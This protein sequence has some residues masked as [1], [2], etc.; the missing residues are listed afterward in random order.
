MHTRSLLIILALAVLIL[1]GVFAS[2]RRPSTDGPPAAGTPVAA[3]A[4]GIPEVSLADGE[5]LDLTADEADLPFAGKTRRVLAYN[6]SVP[7]PLIRVAQGSE[8]AIRFRNRLDH[9]TT[10]HAH[11]VRM[12][13]AFDGVPDV[14]QRPVKPGE[15]FTYR[16]RFPDP[17]A[18]WYH[19]HIR[20]DRD[21]DLGLLGMFLVTP[22][23]AAYWNPVDRELPLVLDDILLDRGEPVPYP[24]DRADHALMGRFGETM[25]VNGQ[26][27]YRLDAKT[28]ERI[29]LFVLNA[30]NTRPFRLA[31]R[32]ADLRL[33]GGDGGRMEREERTDAVLLGPSERAV[34]E[35]RFNRAGSYALEHRTPDRTYAL[36]TVEVTGEDAV[37]GSEPADR[38]ILDLPAH[39]AQWRTAEPDKA[40]RFDV[41][42]RM[43][44]AGQQSGM[45]GHGM[46]MGETMGSGMAGDLPE[47]G[48]EWED[49]G[50]PMN[51]M[52][53]S[54]LV[55][56]KLVDAQSGKENEDIDWRFPKGGFVKVLLLNDPDSAH[57]M[58]HPIHFHGQ[59]FLVLSRDGVPQTNLVWKDTVFVRAGETV[60]VLIEVSNPGTWAMHCHIP[61]HMESGMMGTFEII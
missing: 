23:D 20:E 16:L 51:A 44:P 13:N 55:T 33:V 42:L 61:E 56:W 36:G 48:I 35:V 34:V 7:G 59:R 28:G 18:Y 21:Q 58:Q 32:G 8:V 19:P 12:D 49:P 43:M 3:P 29:R 5:T 54:K 26:T 24:A 31:I 27:R 45:G 52:S 40:L 38:G 50:D 14:T 15:T 41:D 9:D 57:P 22:A 53:T 60:D 25:L 4:A 46:M 37:P 10:L 30:A 6:G 2:G 17:G 39:L 11:G 47:D 1:G